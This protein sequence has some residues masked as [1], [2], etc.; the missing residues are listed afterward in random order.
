MTAVA[1]GVMFGAMYLFGLYAASSILAA[2]GLLLTFILYVRLR[3]KG[4]AVFER[5]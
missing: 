1:A 5:L 2:L 3:N 4:E